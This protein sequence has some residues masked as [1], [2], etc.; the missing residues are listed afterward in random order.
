MVNSGTGLVTAVSAGS[1]TI[2]YT[3]SG[4]GLSLTASKLLTVNP[5]ASAGTVSGASPLCIGATSTYTSSGNPGGT[6]SSSAPGIATVNSG[7]GLV[8][9]VSAGSATITYTVNGC[10]GP[11]SANKTVIINQNANAGELSG[12]TILC[13][14]ATAAYISSGQA[15]G[16]WSSDAPGIATVNSST[17][18]VT[19]A[20]AGTATITYT[21]NGCNGPASATLLV[22]VKALPQGSLSANGPF[23]LTGTGMLTWTSTAGIAP[24]TL[25][26]FD[27]AANRTATGVFSGVPF[28]VFTNPVTSTTT[29]SLVSVSDANCTRATGFT[30]DSATIMVTGGY[31]SG[32]TILG[33]TDVN[34]GTG[35]TVNGDIGNTGAGKKVTVGKNS[36]VN[37]LIRSSI[38]NLA[39]P[40]TVTGGLFYTPAVV[41]LPPMLFNTAVVPPG[42]FTVADNAVV[43]IN[44]NYNGLNIGKNTLVTING[45]IYGNVSIGSGSTVTFTATDVSINQL[46]LSNGNASP[47]KYTSLNFANNAN[48]RIKNSV[49]LGSRNRVNESSSKRVTFYMGDASNSA[50]QYNINS[51][52]TRVNAGIYMPV[53]TI[54]FTNNGPCTMTG[55]F[56]SQYFSGSK[57][58]SWNCGNSIP[59]VEPPVTGFVKNNEFNVKVFPNPSTEEF[60]IQVLT[61]NNSPVTVT[62]TDVSG[63]K[64]SSITIPVSKLTVATVGKGLVGGIYYAQVIQGDQL[65]TVKLVKLN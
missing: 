39:Q 10:N 29:Y 26:Y 52:D 60:N 63:R 47:L 44:T 1:A 55:T 15:G 31:C 45:T 7:T 53:G 2:T 61:N 4:C 54:N 33:L 9:A 27:G 32:Y 56:I 51:T 62:I 14:G 11:A 37:G 34:L 35:N 25:V 64:I 36:T 19:A 28:N 23:I 40:V 5:N 50:E 65:Q 3:V 16:T 22:T 46:S 42:N 21:V 8:T 6:W 59:E 58:V 41:T 38:I 20:G 13:V 49:S 30:E 12:T 17:G 18:L 57:S 24:F 43:T 48:V